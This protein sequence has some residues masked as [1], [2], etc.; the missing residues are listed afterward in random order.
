MMN[1]FFNSDLC[2]EFFQKKYSQTLLLFFYWNVLI[3][4]STTIVLA[5]HCFVA[6]TYY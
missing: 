2:D 6:Q 1:F 4:F 3:I 5:R